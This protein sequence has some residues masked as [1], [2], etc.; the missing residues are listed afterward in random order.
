MGILDRIL[1]LKKKKCPKC[2]SIMEKSGEIKVGIRNKKRIVYSCFNCGYTGYFLKINMKR[3]YR[4]KR[5]DENQI[6]TTRR[7]QQIK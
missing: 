7:I 1:N 3:S 5:L 6:I 4:Q 2:G